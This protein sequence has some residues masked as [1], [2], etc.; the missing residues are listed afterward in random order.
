MTYISFL[1]Q[2][3]NENSYTKMKVSLGFQNQGCFERSA[4]EEWV[5]DKENEI[6]GYRQD[7]LVTRVDVA[8]VTTK[9]HADAGG[10]GFHLKPC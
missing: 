8:H 10:L 7:R 6:E 5:K 4:I 3:C 9:G 2:C 1:G